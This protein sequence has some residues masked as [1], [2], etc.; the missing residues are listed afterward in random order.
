MYV[1]IYIYISIFGF[2]HHAWVCLRPQKQSRQKILD[3][4]LH[5][6]SL[7]RFVAQL[8]PP[9]DTILVL[10]LAWP[11]LILPELSWLYKTTFPK[12]QN[13]G[14]PK[15]H[16]K[17]H[18][19]FALLGPLPPRL[20]PLGL[21]PLGLLPLGFPPLGLLPLGLLPLGLPPP[22]GRGSP[23]RKTPGRRSPGRGSPGRRTPGRRSLG[24][25]SLGRR[26]PGRGTLGCE[27]LGVASVM[28]AGNDFSLPFGA[29]EGSG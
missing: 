21:L 18:T 23:G 20:P 5:C 7:N 3:E 29:N 6:F 16:Q 2:S 10:Y 26:A 28:M 11:Y 25:G 14:H 27:V 12:S 9:I 13:P 17:N 15:E 8:H 22:H 1:Y 24:R 19:K 4:V